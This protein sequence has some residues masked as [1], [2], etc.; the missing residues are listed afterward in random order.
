M[1]AV[2]IQ[3]QMMPKTKSFFISMAILAA[4]VFGFKQLHA[5]YYLN[6]FRPQADSIYVKLQYACEKDKIDIYNSLAFYHS[7]SNADSAIYYAEQALELEKTYPDEIRRA[8]A[9]RHLGNAY[10]LNNQYGRALFHLNQAM[11]T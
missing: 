3:K 6:M 1:N 4:F 9:N 2:L 10:A 7:F 8:D 11:N 5:Q